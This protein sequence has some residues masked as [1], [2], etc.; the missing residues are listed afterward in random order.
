M[1]SL[2][3]Q[4]SG[5][6]SQPGRAGSALRLRSAGAE[7][8]APQRARRCAHVGLC[9]RLSAF[10][11]PWP[12]WAYRPSRARAGAGAGA[13]ATAAA[14]RGRVQRSAG[15]EP[16]LC[17]R[18]LGPTSFFLI[19]VSQR[20]RWSR[21]SPRCAHP[22]PHPP[23]RARSDPTHPPD[24]PGARAPASAPPVPSA[25][26]SPPLP[27]PRSRP[28]ACP[29]RR[30][31]CARARWSHVLVGGSIRSYLE[32]SCEWSR[33]RARGSKGSATAR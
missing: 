33:Q 22:A 1:P 23:S 19:V 2:R 7:G 18:T 9:A 6:A 26:P 5:A 12:R 10:A 13:A 17:P 27:C 32:S 24:R 28:C 4:V 30:P 16:P 14:A 25:L 15:S 11:G 20:A 29:P 3:A 31:R 21:S 8:P